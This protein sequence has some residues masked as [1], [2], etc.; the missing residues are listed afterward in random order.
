MEDVETG[1]FL[2]DWDAFDCTGKSRAQIFIGVS[3]ELNAFADC[4]GNASE[5][6][7]SARQVCQGGEV[8]FSKPTNGINQQRSSERQQRNGFLADSFF[9]RLPDLQEV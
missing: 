3:H 5:C 7:E 4:E 1:T 6:V 8:C 9:D 2:I